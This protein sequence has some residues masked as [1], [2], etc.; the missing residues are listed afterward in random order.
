VKGERELQVLQV[1]RGPQRH[2]LASISKK[3]RT[4]QRPHRSWSHHFPRWGMSASK[5]KV[6]GPSPVGS[7]NGRITGKK[8]FENPHR[9][10]KETSMLL[11][12]TRGQLILKKNR[13]EKAEENETHW[14]GKGRGR[15]HCGR[16]VGARSQTSDMRRKLWKRKSIRYDTGK[17]NQNEPKAC[18][19]R[20]KG[21]QTGPRKTEGE[22]SGG[23][24]ANGRD[25]LPDGNRTGGHIEKKILGGW[26]TGEKG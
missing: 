12:C 10:E 14:R 17:R 19:R 9:G 2:F 3:N 4:A 1:D 13:I 21:G 11:P 23:R 16:P 15:R 5:K 20:G 24:K 6:N 18:P 26:R 22:K 25:T 7:K 8:R